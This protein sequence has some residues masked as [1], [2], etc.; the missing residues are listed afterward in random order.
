MD[1]FTCNSSNNIIKTNK[2]INNNNKKYIVFWEL[3]SF[4]NSGTGK[5][6]MLSNWF[7][8]YFMDLM[9]MN[10]IERMTLDNVIYIQIII[11]D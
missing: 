2:E 5:I 3:S 9:N 1:S 6:V 8:V 7:L 4:G 10:R 11:Q